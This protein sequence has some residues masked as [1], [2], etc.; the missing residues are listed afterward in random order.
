MNTKKGRDAHKMLKHLIIIQ[1][2][3]YKL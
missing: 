1:I 3:Q 2:Q